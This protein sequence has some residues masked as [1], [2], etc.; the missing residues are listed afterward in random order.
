MQKDTRN[1]TADNADE[2]GYKERFFI[3]LSII[4]RILNLYQRKSA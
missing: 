3:F 4:F 1:L 2:R